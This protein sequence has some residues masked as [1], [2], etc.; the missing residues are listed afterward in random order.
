MDIKT[1]L[2][3]LH[4]VGTA[5]GV[6]GATASDFLFFKIL[7]KGFLDKTEYDFLKTISKVV[8]LGLLI[9]FLTG[10]GF[11]VYYRLVLPADG[12]IYNPKL[13]AKIAVVLVILFNGIL[14]HAKV[15][16]F[17]EKNLGKRFIETDFKNKAKLIFTTGAI[18][19]TSWYSALVLGAWREANFKYGFLEIFGIYLGIVLVAIFFANIIGPKLLRK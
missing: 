3:I 1:F 5:L 19:I 15:F 9:L 10:F 2:I 6:G 8:W 13:W 16:A 17:F 18:S 14:M 11:L 7:K 4:I 12:L